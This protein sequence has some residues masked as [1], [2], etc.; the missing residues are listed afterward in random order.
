[1]TVRLVMLFKRSTVLGEIKETFI[2]GRGGGV[3]D[4]RQ[5]LASKACNYR[6]KKKSRTVLE[7]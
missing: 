4:K 5:K 6:E 3:E 2:S 7:R 1:M